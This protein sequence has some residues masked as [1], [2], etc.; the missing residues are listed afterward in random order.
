MTAINWT[1]FNDLIFRQQSAGYLAP[2]AT[3]NNWLYNIIWCFISLIPT[4]FLLTVWWMILVLQVIGSLK[5]RAQTH[6]YD[7]TKILLCL[8]LENKNSLFE[9][10]TFSTC[11][12][13]DFYALLKE[14]LLCNTHHIH[15]SHLASISNDRFL[16]GL[17]V[18]AWNTTLLQSK[19][20]TWEIQMHWGLLWFS[21]IEMSY[22]VK[23]WTCSVNCFPDKGDWIFSSSVSR[24][25]WKIS[26]L[27]CNNAYQTAKPEVDKIKSSLL[28]KK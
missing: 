14:K 8:F 17:N 3:A 10:A 5:Y 7:S 11:T 28:F 19:G 21:N 13:N 4:S 26:T 20:I 27:V 6:F 2:L 23:W 16:L 9:V 1:I 24:K 18:N 15:V 22:W 12:K 25:I